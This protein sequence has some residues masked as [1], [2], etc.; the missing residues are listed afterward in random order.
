M[1]THT[2]ANSQGIAKAIARE[3][4]LK[5]EVLRSLLNGIVDPNKY[6]EKTVKV[7]VGRRGRVYT[8]TAP[9]SHHNSSVDAV[10]RHI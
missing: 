9:M 10:M 3:A 6:P 2:V 8:R 5:G 1:R 7:E 4:G